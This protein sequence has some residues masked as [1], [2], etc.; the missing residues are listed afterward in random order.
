MRNDQ[1]LRPIP[2]YNELP[3]ALQEQVDAH[4]DL[5]DNHHLIFPRHDPDIIRQTKERAA[6]LVISALAVTRH[7]TPS[8]LYF[9]KFL[10]RRF[11]RGGAMNESIK[12]LSIRQPYA[13]WLCHPGL[14]TQ[15]G[16]EPKTI[17]NRDWN[18]RFRGDFLI[19]ASRTFEENAFASWCSV[20]PYLHHVVSFDVATYPKGVILGHATLTEV[21]TASE[22]RW[23][24]GR[25]GLVLAEACLLPQP[26]PYRGQPGFFE[27]PR[28]LL[29]D[30]ERASESVSGALVL[31]CVEKP[32]NLLG[33]TMKHMSTASVEIVVT[34]SC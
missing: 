6:S 26:I 3:P 30:G 10:Q 13:S 1:P 17:E 16:R 31:K 33:A 22:S 11:R 12:C 4:V 20:F 15:A 28:A 18:T 19:H 27:V 24:R 2:Q 25:Y 23:F 21:V 34:G 7:D 8:L 5:L 14:F 9:N 32:T 29:E